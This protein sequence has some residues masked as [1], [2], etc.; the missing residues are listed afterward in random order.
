MITAQFE[1]VR[2][3]VLGSSFVNTTYAPSAA[4][5]ALV[6]V[7]DFQLQGCLHDVIMNLLPLF[8]YT[9]TTEGSSG[10]VDVEDVSLEDHRVVI[11]YAVATATPYDRLITFEAELLPTEGND[12]APVLQINHV[13]SIQRIKF[14]EFPEY[15]IVEA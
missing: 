5:A 9:D 14:T 4:I 6:Q 13:L 11:S 1:T 2:D 10:I 3:Y 8:G 15:E 7:E 12:D